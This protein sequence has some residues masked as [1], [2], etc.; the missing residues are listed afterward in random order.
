MEEGFGKVGGFKWPWG[1]VRSR[2]R[3]LQA[4][5]CPVE[6]APTNSS[7]G[8]VEEAMEDEIILGGV[9]NPASTQ[10]WCEVR[11]RSPPFLTLAM[12]SCG[13]P[14]WGKILRWSGNG[15]KRYRL[16]WQAGRIRL[17][18]LRNNPSRRGYIS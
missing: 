3:G 6:E 1:A 18:S 13:P 4:G 14:S 12:L 2:V 9:Y 15:G 7:A 5:F 8:V 16:I 10:T 17:A 11:D